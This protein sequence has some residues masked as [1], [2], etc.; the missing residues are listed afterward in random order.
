[1]VSPQDNSCQASR[2]LQKGKAGQT[3]PA[4]GSPVPSPRAW[5]DTCLWTG[6]R[7]VCIWEH[8]HILDP[9]KQCCCISVGRVS[10][11]G[12]PK[13]MHTVLSP[14]R[15]SPPRG[16]ILH[17]HTTEPKSLQIWRIKWPSLNKIHK[18]GYWFPVNSQSVIISI[19]KWAIECLNRLSRQSFHQQSNNWSWFQKQR[20]SKKEL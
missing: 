17:L 18:T 5:E 15:E 4:I 7:V 8:G 6:P 11:Q 13:L 2:A 1:M 20:K 10:Q 14:Q 3:F 12:L 16:L 19:Y 9:V